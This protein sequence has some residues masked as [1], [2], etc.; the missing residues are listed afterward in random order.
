MLPISVVI[1][2]YTERRWYDLLAAIESVQQQS[3]PPF[4]I[5]VVVDHNDDLLARLRAHTTD[6]RIVGSTRTPGL[7]GARNTGVAIATG[8]IVAFLDDDAEADADWLK[9]LGAG[10]ED[11]RV[12]GVGGAIEPEW[13]DVRPRWFP[14][15]FDWVV[16]CTYRGMPEFTSPVRNLIGAN[17]SF[18]REVF[19]VAGGFNEGV[20]RVGTVPLGCE[21]SEICI[22]AG[23]RWPQ[24]VFL[25]EPRARVRHNVPRERARWSYFRARCYGE[26]LSKAA[27]SRLVGP[28]RGL[29]SE[30][31]YVRRTLPRGI[32][33]GLKEGIG[34]DRAGAGRSGAIVVGL[35]TTTVGYVRGRV[36]RPAQLAPPEIANPIQR[37][38]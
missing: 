18:R 10:Y 6:V 20:G 28:G 9:H 35:A 19:E 8:E 15:E 34:P 3:S 21:E 22:R 13:Q 25:Y 32:M 14:P 31:T 16:G 1:C 12:L 23:A 5:I 38:S 4:E 29:A 11:D 2:A 24:R 17:M 36:A 26:G 27:V 7:A 30:R 33:Q 37:G